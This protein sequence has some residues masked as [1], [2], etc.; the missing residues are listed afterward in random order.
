[1]MAAEPGHQNCVYGADQDKEMD[2][3]ACQECGVQDQEGQ[4]K[5]L[6]QHDKDEAKCQCSTMPDEYELVG[7]SPQDE[8]EHAEHDI[9]EHIMHIED[10]LKTRS[11][12]IRQSMEETNT[13]DDDKFM[14]CEEGPEEHKDNEPNGT[15]IA[16]EELEEFLGYCD[17]DDYMECNMAAEEEPKFLEMALKVALDPGC[18]E[19]VADQ[20]EAPGYAVK[21]SAG[22]VRGHK[23]IAAGGHRMANQGEFTLQLRASEG[24][25]RS[26]KSTFQVAKVTRPLWSVSKICDEGF[27][28]V[29]NKN[30]TVIR[31]ETDDKEVCSFV[32]EHGLYVATLKVRNP[33]HKSF[34]RQAAKA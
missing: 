21:P 4:T 17:I 27:N 7:D 2:M 13:Q 19:H 1:M 30:K 10:M 32:R 31:R 3:F 14:E 24:K 26:L 6:C 5:T 29:F 9:W 28:V 34:I 11:A 20:E 22:S 12:R 8:L 15:A 33:K 16:Q 18:G 23:S 25:G